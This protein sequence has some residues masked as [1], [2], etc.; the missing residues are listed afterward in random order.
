MSIMRSR[1][2]VKYVLNVLNVHYRRAMA[3]VQITRVMLA[4]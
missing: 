3:Q 4:G 1:V 2:G